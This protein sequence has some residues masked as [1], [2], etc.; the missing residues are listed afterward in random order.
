MV[1]NLKK[2]AT[3][4]LKAEAKT[5]ALKAKTDV[6]KVSSATKGRSACYPTSRNPRP[7][8]FRGI[9]NILKKCHPLEM[10]VTTMLLSNTESATKKIEDSDTLLFIVNVKD[11]SHQIKQAT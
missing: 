8:S 7:C 1:P 4:P 5:K 6:L 2:E 3:A 11:N 10:I 9:P